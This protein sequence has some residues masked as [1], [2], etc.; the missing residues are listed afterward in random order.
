[1]MTLISKKSACLLNFMFERF[2]DGDSCVL[3][4]APWFGGEDLRPL[5]NFITLQALTMDAILDK[6]DA[7]NAFRP[8]ATRLLDFDTR[9]WNISLRASIRFLGDHN[10]NQIPA[11]F[12]TAL[13]N[14]RLVVKQTA[15]HLPYPLS[16]KVML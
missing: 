12:M 7:F 10:Q 6:Y 2:D 14:L 3:L 1:M 8:H 13:D 15:H 5:V 4:N 11:P 9:P 16:I